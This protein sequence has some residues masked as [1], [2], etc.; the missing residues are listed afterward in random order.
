MKHWSLKTKGLVYIVLVALLPLVISGIYVYESIKN[1]VIQMKVDKIELQQEAKDYMITTSIA[2]IINDLKMLASSEVSMNPSTNLNQLLKSKLNLM[3]SSYISLGF[4]NNSNNIQYYARDSKHQEFYFKTA[5][6]EVQVIIDGSIADERGNVISYVSVPVFDKSNSFIGALFSSFYFPPNYYQNHDYTLSMEDTYIYTTEGQVIFHPNLVSYTIEKASEY[7]ELIKKY[8]E[9][10]GTEQVS[11]KIINYSFNN[12]VMVHRIVNEDKWMM[13]D[14]IPMSEIK[15]ETFPNFVRIF[16]SIFIS[17]AIVSF[18]F[19]AYFNSIT[20]RLFEIVKVTKQGANG[21]FNVKHLDGSIKD[22]IGILSH[23]INGMMNR[24]EIMF[25]RLDAVINQNQSPVMV[26]DEFYRFSYLNK[27]AEEMLGVSSETVIGKFTPISFMDFE[28]V[29]NRAKRFSEEVGHPIPPGPELFLEL[30]RKYANYDMEF[31]I[32]SSNG[33]RIPVYDRSSVIR[34]KSGKMLGIVSILQDLSKQREVEQA[35]NRLQ[36]IVESARDLIASVDRHSNIIYINE[37]GKRMLGIQDNEA[38]NLA[39]CLPDDIHK[40]LIE[41]SQKARNE[42]YFE[43]ESQFINRLGERINASI[44]IVTH[45]DTFT[46]ELIYSCIA[47]DLTE[48]LDTQEKLVEATELAEKA[49]AAKGTFLALMSH[50]IRTPLN[51]IIGLS[52]LLEKTKLDQLQREYTEK[53]KSSSDTLLHIVNDILDFSK[54]EVSKIELEQRL[55]NIHNVIEHVSLQVSHYLGGK[56]HFEFKIVLDDKLPRLLVGDSLRLEQILNNLCVNAVKFTPQGTVKLELKV[57]HITD[58]NVKVKIA[59]TDTGIGMSEQQMNKLFIPFTQA[60]SST[61][62]QF[63]GTG[64]GLVIAQ[65]F[66][67]LMGGEIKVESA[68]NVGS[69]FSFIIDF[70]YPEQLEQS[71]AMKFPENIYFAWVIEDNKEMMEYWI[72]LLAKQKVAAISMNSWKDGYY[73]LCRLGKGF[74]PSVI[75]LDMEMPDMYGIDTWLSFKAEADKLNIPIVILTTTFGHEELAMLDEAAQPKYVITK[76]VQPYQLKKTIFELLSKKDRPEIIEASTNSLVNQSL[77]NMSDN[78]KYSILVAEDNKIN[79]LVAD[80]MLKLANV[81][82]TIVNNGLEAIKVL[83]EQQFDLILMDIHMPM[84]DGIE[85]TKQIRANTKYDHIPIIAVTANIVSS[86][87]QQYK[88]IGMQHI[89]TK[90]LEILTLNYVLNEYLYGEKIKVEK[91]KLVETSSTIQVEQ[92][93]E[94]LNGKVNIY[95]HMLEQFKIDYNNFA[96]SLVQNVEVGNL[97][98]VQRMLHTLKGASSYLG[99]TQ[100]NKI[101]ARLERYAIEADIVL[102]EQHMPELVSHIEDVLNDIAKLLEKY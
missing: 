8:I 86:D 33:E 15:K 87:H 25:S 34:D 31:T 100:L 92:A 41:S 3:D 93:L 27:A 82:V 65:N 94:R 49:A 9:Q 40:M 30:R 63:G 57:E 59:V 80:E 26:L 7:D 102:L 71:L 51:G 11:S 72:E 58:K 13:V 39:D 61:T 76:P 84:M 74:V 90:P 62:R 47:R 52:Q 99:A 17:I 45:M 67:K 56:D 44:S 18:V 89:I 42:G 24:L 4:I 96:E 16:G 73:R 68:L 69:T 21:S 23:S 66:V 54:L 22:E 98:A 85:A 81:N 36:E 97:K 43:M 53:I 1:D 91:E 77:I 29:A 5:P 64:L 79:Q 20:R 78:K 14:I 28:E 12:Y 101:A 70:N 32:V 83:N 75:I 35:R 46:G 10:L 38:T 19:Y 88:Q 55:F 48:L 37:A 2:S 6:Q 60:D 50:E 95:R